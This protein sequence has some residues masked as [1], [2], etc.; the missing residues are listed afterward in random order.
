MGIQAVDEDAS[1]M[2]DNTNTEM[3]SRLCLK[4]IYRIYRIWTAR[5]I[6]LVQGNGSRESYLLYYIIFIDDM[7]SPKYIHVIHSLISFL[8]T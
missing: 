8:V 2:I 5:H 7:L 3:L 6:E 4:C 1:G